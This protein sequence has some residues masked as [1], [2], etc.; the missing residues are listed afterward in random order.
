MIFL[1]KIILYFFAMEFNIYNFYFGNL[2]FFFIC[3]S[4]IKTLKINYL[5]NEF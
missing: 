5:R 3:Y 4:A 2:V 1:L